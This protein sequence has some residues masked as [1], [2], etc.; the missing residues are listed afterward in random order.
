MNRHERVVMIGSLVLF[1]LLAVVAAAALAYYARF[2]NGIYPYHGA[3][4]MSAYMHLLVTALPCWLIICWAVGLYDPDW[5]LGGPQEYARATKACSFGILLLVVVAFWGRE[6]ILSRGWSVMTWAFSVVFMVGL[7]F[8]FRRII[9]HLRTRGLFSTTTLIVGVSEHTKAIAAQLA[10]KRNGV[11]LLGFLDDYLPLGTPVLENLEVLGTPRD[12][13]R[14]VYAL[15]IQEVIIFPDALAWESF[16]ETMLQAASGLNGTEVKLA[17][18]F[19]EILTT[20]VKVSH[21]AFVPLLVLQRVRLTGFYALLKTA[22]D[23]ILATALFVVTAPLMGLITLT[24]WLLHSRPIFDRPQVLGLR[25]EPFRTIKFNTGLVGPARRSLVHPM[26]Q[27]QAHL[28]FTSRVGRLL[29]RTKLDKLPQ[30]V[31]VLRGRMSLVGPRTICVGSKERNG[32]WLPSLLTVKPGIT[33]PWAV[34]HSPSVEDETRLM[35]Y[36]IRNWTIWFD[37]QV[38]FQ[39]AKCLLERGDKCAKP[40]EQGIKAAHNPILP[41]TWDI[42][43]VS[44]ENNVLEKKGLVR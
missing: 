9:Y 8:G 44:A 31:D 41:P 22:M 39:T 21:K 27:D 29:F 3:V 23:H 4:N 14:L 13:K 15:H 34:S 43:P 24:M 35:L 38:L 11:R 32:Q 2:L 12:L 37:L 10:I 26:G 16:Q 6:I 5:L 36:Y 20:D 28:Q 40:V 18:G 30:L 1:D 33:G 25:G 42:G 7:R 19:Y 17:P